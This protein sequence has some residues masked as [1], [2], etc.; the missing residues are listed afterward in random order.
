MLVDQTF[1][2]RRE[3]LL[4]LADARREDFLLLSRSRTS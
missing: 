2:F 1:T 4:P 3:D